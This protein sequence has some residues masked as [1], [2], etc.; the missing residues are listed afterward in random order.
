[1][2]DAGAGGCGEAA[3][4]GLRETRGEEC[5]LPTGL[6]SFSSTLR[7]LGLL[8]MGRRSWGLAEGASLSGD[9]RCLAERGEA[10]SLRSE[11]D[12][13]ALRIEGRGPWG[14]VS[15][16]SDASYEKD[17]FRSNVELIWNCRGTRRGL[18]RSMR[19]L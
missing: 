15:V 10:A 12:S 6:G 18:E 8:A 9:L 13:A 19:K 1:M 14:D 2:R 11:V 4:E 5:L 17:I 16:E 3:D 7:I